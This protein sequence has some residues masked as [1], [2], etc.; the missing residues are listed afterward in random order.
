MESIGT[1]NP[2]NANN[3]TSQIIVTLMRNSGFLTYAPR[4]GVIVRMM[5]RG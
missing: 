3:Q 2:E 5:I 4:V 1:K